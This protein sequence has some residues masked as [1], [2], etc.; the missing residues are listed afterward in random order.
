MADVDSELRALIARLYEHFNAREIEAVIA[1]MVPDVDWP[2]A[3]EGTRITGHD[4]VR[5]YWLGQFAQFD[6]RVAPIGFEALGDGRVRVRVRQEL[7]ELNG[8]L[9]GQGEV[10][11][12]YAFRDGLIERMDIVTAE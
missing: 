11:H 6:P 2:N 9:I 4:A 7:Y 3:L 1:L 8:D 5:E 10:F 12:D